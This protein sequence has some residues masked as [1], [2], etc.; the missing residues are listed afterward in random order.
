MKFE[1]TEKPKEK[2]KTLRNNEIKVTKIISGNIISKKE[3]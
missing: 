2:K 1:K 3:P